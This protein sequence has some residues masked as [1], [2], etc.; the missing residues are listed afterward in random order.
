[1]PEGHELLIGGQPLERFEFEAGGVA[2]Q[3]IE[4]SRLE[5]EESTVDPALAGLR[6][7]IE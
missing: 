4:D 3:V 5:D 6:L 7:L 1:V 2:V